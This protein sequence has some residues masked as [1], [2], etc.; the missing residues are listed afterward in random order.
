MSKKPSSV[1]IGN[2]IIDIVFTSSENDSRLDNGTVGWSDNYR[3][4]I[5]I[6][7]LVNEMLQKETLLHEMLHFIRYIYQPSN[8]IYD[9]DTPY[10]DI[11]HHFINMYEVSLITILKENKSVREYILG[12]K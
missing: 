4:T 8:L 9:E 12:E 5:V 1:K 6:D 2:R 10:I 7:T 11:E 3:S